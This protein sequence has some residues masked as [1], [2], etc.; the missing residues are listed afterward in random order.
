MRVNVRFH[1]IVGDIARRK[2]QQVEIADGATVAELLTALADEDAGFGGVAKQVR[3]VVNGQN[4]GR[5]DVLQADD[6]V[7]LVRAIGGGER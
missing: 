3:A 1:G 5:D 2:S 6:E 4:A 7:M